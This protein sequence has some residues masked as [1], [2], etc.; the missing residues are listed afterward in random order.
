[1]SETRFTVIIPVR[2][3]SQRLPGKV[4]L[5]IAG[6][7]MLRHVYEHC[8]RS[9]AD[10][11][12]VAT[13]DERIRDVAQAFGAEVVM[14]SDAHRSGTERIIEAVNQLALDDHQIVVNVQGDEPQIPPEVIAQVAALTPEDGVGTLMDTASLEE[15][16]NPDVVKVVCDK[17]ARALY[18]SRS[19]I[20]CP[21]RLRDTDRTSALWQR[22]LGIY[23]YRV[24][25]LKRWRTWQPCALE[26]QEK[27]EQLR[28]LYHGIPIM[29]A[30]TCAVVPAGV[31]NASDLERVRAQCKPM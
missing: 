7:P 10:A 11:V 15:C 20:P 27:L 5:D 28:P 17:N 23:A 21:V 30:Q 18:F 14:T 13:C 31:D 8:V 2:Y 16:E 22:H 26:Q 6:Q 4:L 25:L 29:V 12:Y 9:G 19:V 1:M 3:A 24:S